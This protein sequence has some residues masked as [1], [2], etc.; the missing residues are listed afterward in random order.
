MVA[1]YRIW[2]KGWPLQNCWHIGGHTNGLFF[3]IDDRDGGEV[4]IGSHGYRPLIN[5]AMFGEALAIAAIAAETGRKDLADEFKAKA[6]WIKQL[7]QERLWDPRRQFFMILKPNG[8]TRSNVRELYGYAPWYFNL[9][10]A[11]FESGWSQLMNPQGFF[12]PYGPSFAEQRHPGFRIAYTGH[13]CQWNGPSWPY[14]TSVTLTALANLLNDYQQRVVDCR[15]FFDTLLIYTRSC[16]RVREDGRIVPWI[17]ENLNPYTGEWLSRAII[18]LREKGRQ[19]KE[20]GKDYN[21]STFCD[22][23]ISGLVGLRPRADE[24]IVVNPLVPEGVWDWFCLDRVPYHGHMLTIMWDKDGAR[25]GRGKGFQLLVN[26]KV[27]ARHG[28]L[29]R[30]SVS[31]NM[32]AL[33]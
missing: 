7:V 14:A 23:I 24:T 27:M 9:P 25:F 10:D 3:T 22:L 31:V 2:E 16:R 5:A 26:G 20:R 8:K 13:H 19:P 30:V 4:S 21:H 1:N 15:A 17:D 28:R 33:M 12:A 32:N 18:L 11:G 29:E 6:A